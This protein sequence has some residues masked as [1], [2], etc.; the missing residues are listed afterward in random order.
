MFKLY[1]KTAATALLISVAFPSVVA[2]FLLFFYEEFS[3]FQVVKQV[4]RQVVCFSIVFFVGVC[5]WRLWDR[6]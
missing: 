2:F 3:V 1:L 4:S 6:P 5:L